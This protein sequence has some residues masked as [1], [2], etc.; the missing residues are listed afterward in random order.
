M[1]IFEQQEAANEFIDDAQAS[2]DNLGKSLEE[3]IQEFEKK[4]M[5]EEELAQISSDTV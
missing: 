2:I 4:N 3:I 1:H 5:T